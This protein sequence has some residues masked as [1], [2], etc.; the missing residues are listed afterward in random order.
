MKKIIPL[1]KSLKF[2]INVFVTTLFVVIIALL[3]YRTNQNQRDIIRAKEEN[4]NQ[5]AIDTINR[6]FT[7]SYQILE[8]SSAQI[9]ASP[10][11]V[12]SIAKGDTE[13]LSQLVSQPHQKL[14]EVGVEEFH[15]YLPDDRSLLNLY[16]P[17]QG[18]T[19]VPCD[20]SIVKKIN[21]DP[22][23]RAI[24]GVDECCHGV[25]LRYIAPVFNNNEYI[26]SVELGMEIESRIL[27]IF[28]NV[29]GGEWYLYSLNEN[30][31]SLLGGTV[32][33]DSYPVE[34]N[35][36]LAASLGNGE[37]NK[38][39]KPPY[40]IQKIPFANYQGEHKHYFKRIFDNSGLITLQNEY[41]KQYLM[42]G[43]FTAILGVLLLWTVLSHLLNPLTYLEQNARKIEAGNLEQPI[44]VKSSDEIGYLAKT[45]ENMR[46]ALY[47]R[48][49][50]LKE[51]SRIDP[52]TG[53]H[54]RFSFDQKL[55]KI[56]ENELN[57]TSLI[58]VDID[59]L[60]E[61]ND[62]QGH[63]AGDEH[64]VRCTEIIQRVLRR[65]EDK[66]FRIGGDEFMIVL[67]FTDKQRGE[68]ILARIK[69]EFA[70]FNLTLKEDENV[71]SV[72]LG[73]GVCEGN[74]C[75]VEKAMAIADKEMY[76]DKAAKK[77]SS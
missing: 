60:K 15:F 24:K 46:Q 72:S 7:V 45:M 18:E 65:D 50:E 49:M 66:L 19:M 76:K 51:H 75:T 47:K 63:A 28:K 56:I 31:Q 34:I 68:M 30:K 64:I 74:P 42:Y 12:E 44:E 3:I 70:L 32:L 10:L 52:L 67:P 43:M 57:P 13:K 26:G 36:E 41:T 25:F 35:T 20:S 55:K 1:H 53:I 14:Q 4:L 77:K 62:N 29:S 9:T 33:E 11:I 21:A 6:R 59:D 37:V 5:I 39:E 58:M 23:H 16:E 22:E 8:T 71:L 69:K 2:K 40:V 61:I 54:N 73:L 48:E 38:I 17:K 27:N